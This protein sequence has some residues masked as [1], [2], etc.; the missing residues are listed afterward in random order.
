MR[1]LLKNKQ[2]MKYSLQVA[3]VPA[4]ET[5]DDGNIKFETYVDDDGNEFPLLDDNGNKIP[6]FQQPLGNFEVLYSEP[7][8]FEASIAMSGGEAQP[9]EYGLSIESYEAVII[10]EANAV[11]L[12]EGAIVWFQNEPQYISEDPIHITVN[13]K[14][15][16]GK[17]AKKTSADFRVLKKSPSLNFDKYI[18]GAVNK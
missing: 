8:P 7:I 13:D 12:T 5:D 6:V 16:S 4:F 2:K 18:L 17:F 11:P 10:T 9:V 3:T 15:I 14:E 1:T